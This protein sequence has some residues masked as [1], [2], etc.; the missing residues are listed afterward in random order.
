MRKNYLKNHEFSQLFPRGTKLPQIDAIRD[1]L[2][3]IDLEGLK[4]INQDIIKKAVEN[5]V[6]E[7]VLL[8]D[9]WW[10][11][12]MEQSFLSCP[13]CLKNTKGNKIHSFHSGAVIST[14]GKSPKLVLGFEM[15]KPGEDS[16]LPVIQFGLT[17]AKI[18]ASIP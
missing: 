16:P 4:Q 6:F 3:V 9:M 11:R 14:V 12:L 13:E 8:M 17:T 7:N 2:K 10:L 18:S 1:A 5:K 15:Y